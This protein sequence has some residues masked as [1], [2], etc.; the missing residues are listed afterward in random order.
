MKVKELRAAL[1]ALQDEEAKVR[2]VD[3]ETMLV[4]DVVSLWV[5]DVTA[6]SL[7]CQSDRVHFDGLVPSGYIYLSRI[8][9]W[10][11]TESPSRLY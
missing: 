10:R 1:L 6:V 9:P 7:P 11:G 4:S 2:F 5:K 8:K 3:Y